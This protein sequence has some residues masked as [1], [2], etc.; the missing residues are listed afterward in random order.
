MRCERPQS[1]ISRPGSAAGHE[2]AQLAQVDRLLARRR[3]R[4]VEHARLVV[5]AL[6][7]L[8]AVPEQRAVRRE[9]VT[10]RGSAWFSDARTVVPRPRPARRRRRPSRPARPR[11][12]RA[13]ARSGR[14]WG[15]RRWS[16]A[17]RPPC[18]P[19]VISV[20]ALGRL[21]QPQPA[22]VAVRLAPVVQA[23]DG[24]LA[25]VAALREAHG[26]LVDARLLRHRV[27]VHVEAEPR[28]AGLDAH[29]LRRLLGDRLHVERRAGLADHVHAEQRRHVDAVLARHERVLL[30][31]RRGVEPLA[32]GGAHERQQRARLGHVLVL[33]VA[34]ERVGAEHVLEHGVPDRLGVEPEPVVAAQDRGGRCGASPCG[35][36]RWRSSPAPARAPRRRSRPVPGGSRRPR[37]RAR[38][39]SRGRSGPPA[40][41]TR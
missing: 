38:G 5:V 31:G 13:R 23:R 19:S 30:R 35:R 29:A 28:T 26:A 12:A 37:R 1:S 36:G 33:H 9:P 34:P 21:R 20:P 15:R 10:A 6:G 14:A 32:R 3:S 18:S 25:D 11:G 4:Q 40:R 2:L 7:A 24:L 27:R 39:T 17:A 41:R 8:R 22:Q 16:R